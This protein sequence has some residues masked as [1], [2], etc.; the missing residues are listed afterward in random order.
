ME[1]LPMPRVKQLK[2][3]S[4]SSKPYAEF[5]LFAHQNGQ[6][7]KK[8]LGRL[9]YFG[10]DADAALAKYLDQKDDLHA[11]R[12]P[13]TVGDGLTLRDLANRF[14]TSKKHQM[15]AG[16]LSSRT[17]SD[18]HHISEMLIGFFGKDQLVSA[19]RPDYFDRLRAKLAKTRGPVAIRSEERRV[20]KE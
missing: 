8:I 17:W 14:L 7:C 13:R 15:E 19:L 12:R 6:W 3:G 11:G 1:Y 18:Y 20:G 10:I 4:R 2:E 16:E 9:H 5:P